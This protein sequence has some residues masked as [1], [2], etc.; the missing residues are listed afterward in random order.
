MSKL[1]E[2]SRVLFRHDWSCRDD[3]ARALHDLAELDDEQIVE[4]ERLQPLPTVSMGIK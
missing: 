3:W 1:E 2:M 4:L